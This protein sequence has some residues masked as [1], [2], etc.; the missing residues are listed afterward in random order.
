MS[1]YKQ[2]KAAGISSRA[3]LEELSGFR[4]RTIQD[5]YNHNRKR[6]DVILA[7]AV[8]IKSRKSA[9]QLNPM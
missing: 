9:I 2:M 8:E 4:Q 5:Y 1:A 7:G 3:E 6:F